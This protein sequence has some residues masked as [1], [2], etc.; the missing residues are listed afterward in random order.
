LF[1]FNHE[2]DSISSP[3]MTLTFILILPEGMKFKNYII[4]II[5]IVIIIVII[6]INIV[7]IVIIIINIVILLQ[8]YLCT[9]VYI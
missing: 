6:I 2:F 7:I 4:V 1:F 5:I 9:N 3:L 8:V